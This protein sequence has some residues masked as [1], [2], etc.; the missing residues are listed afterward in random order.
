MGDFAARFSR[1]PAPRQ[2]SPGPR[3]ISDI[4]EACVDALLSVEEDAPA[5]LPAPHAPSG[6]TATISGFVPHNFSRAFEGAATAVSAMKQRPLSGLKVL[7]MGSLIA[8][9]FAARTLADFGADVIKIEPPEG[10]DPLRS[11]R[12]PEGETSVWW[13]VQARN[14]KSVA[15]DLHQREGQELVRK[16][17]LEVDVIVENFRPGTL[18]KWGLDYDS[19]A[20]INPK[21][22]MLRISGY[23][24]S[25]PLRDRPGFGV[26]AEAMGGFRYITGEPGK[27]PVRPGISIGDSLAALHGVIGVMMALYH[28]VAHGGRGQMIDVALYESVFNM[29]EGAVPEYDRYGMIREPAGSAIQGIAPTNAYPTSDGCFVLVAGNGDSIFRRLMTLIGRDDLGNDPALARNPGR[30]AQMARIDAAIGAWTAQRT[31]EQ[32]LAALAEAGVPGGKVYTIKDIAEDTHYA[33]RGM[34]RTITLKDGSALQVPGVVPRLSETPGDFAGGG[35]EI[36]EHTDAVLKDLGIDAEQRAA[37][38]GKGV[39]GK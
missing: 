28:R 9:P 37:L 30:V 15:I 25:G 21:L 12:A 18:E 35:P 31:L 13:H 8:G 39:I 33:A 7:E 4:R 26:V 5:L 32:C 2:V 36:G 22:I 38:R 1:G 34:L 20:A 11:W 14:K 16:L 6:D 3:R 23:G 29:M 24:Q 10:G 27:P 17:A 19:L